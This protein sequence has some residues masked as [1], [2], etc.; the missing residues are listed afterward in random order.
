MKI[1]EIKV[2]EYNELSEESKK[3]AIQKLND[4]YWNDG[5][6]YEHIKEDDALFDIKEED[7]KFP[8]KDNDNILF[9]NN[10]GDLYYTTEGYSFIDCTKAMVINDYTGFY[11]WLK[12]DKN[13]IKKIDNYDIELN[14]EG[15]T[16]YYQKTTCLELVINKE[17]CLTPK[18]LKKLDNAQ[19]IFDEHIS[20]IRKNI[21]SQYEYMQT[22]EYFVDSGIIDEYEFLE[23]GKICR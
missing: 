5:S 8:I 11:K 14:I 13:I 17:N 20:N 9:D 12:L 7:K 3:L 18:Q 21:I 22:A 15:E 4:L 2:Y 1:K 23:N 6:I 10:R 16:G 19:A